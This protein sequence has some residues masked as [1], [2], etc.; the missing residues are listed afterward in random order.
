MRKTVDIAWAGCVSA[1]DPCG[2]R[3]NSDRPS[4]RPYLVRQILTASARKRTVAS[5]YASANVYG[6][7]DHQAIGHR[8]MARPQSAMRA[9]LSGGT[10]RPVGAADPWSFFLFLSSL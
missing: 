9:T 2:D 3:F 8:P 5:R 7:I 10:A 4:R 6:E 1:V